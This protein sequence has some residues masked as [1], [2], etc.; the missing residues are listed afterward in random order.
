MVELFESP[1]SVAQRRWH[2]FEDPAI[3]GCAVERTLRVNEQR[4]NGIDAVISAFEIV[5]DMQGPSTAVRGQLEDGA[6]AKLAAKKCWTVEI[7]RR[8]ENQAAPGIR[9]VNGTVE[10]VEH[11]Q[12]PG[13][14]LSDWL[15]QF[16]NRA[17]VKRAGVYGHSVQITG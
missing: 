9:A 4:A 11:V 15:H 8:V 3:I 13:A 1:G 2:F 7:T 16:K 10:A 14:A 6:T 12:G 5:E 17:I